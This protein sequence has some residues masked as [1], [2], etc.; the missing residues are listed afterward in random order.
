MH[1]A[2]E[3]SGRTQS[4]FADAIVALGLMHGTPAGSRLVS[5]LG[6]TMQQIPSINHGR[7]DSPAHSIT[8]G[9]TERVHCESCS[10]TRRA[11]VCA[12]AAA[13]TVDAKTRRP[14]SACTAEPERQ[15]GLSGSTKVADL[16][17]GGQQDVQVNLLVGWLPH[18]PH[19]HTFTATRIKAV[20][21]DPQTMQRRRTKYRRLV[22]NSIAQ[23]RNGAVCLTTI[24]GAVSTNLECCFEQSQ[25]TH[26]WL[27]IRCPGR[28]GV[29]YLSTQALRTVALHTRGSYQV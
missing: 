8:A 13:S 25:A 28:W 1:G 21:M 16:H 29:W 10:Q 4:N 2:C 15:A 27:P 17:T 5:Y 9:E 20:H 22:E 18:L 19:R 3:L 26:S 7:R 14:A 12:N 11:A 24:L 6:G 23:L